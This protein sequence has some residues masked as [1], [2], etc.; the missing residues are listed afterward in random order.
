MGRI[1]RPLLRLLR[2][3]VQIIRFSVTGQA[4]FIMDIWNRRWLWL[5]G[6]M[7][8]FGLVFGMDLWGCLLGFVDHPVASRSLT[9]SATVPLLGL[10]LAWHFTLV[11]LALWLKLNVDLVEKPLVEWGGTAGKDILIALLKGAGLAVENLSL[12]K[13][14]IVDQETMVKK[15]ASSRQILIA[16]I[17]VRVTLILIPHPITMLISFVT[18]LMVFAL[19]LLIKQFEWDSTGG[20]LLVYRFSLFLGVVNLFAAIVAVFPEK[21]KDFLW[22]LA[23]APGTKVMQLVSIDAW[24]RDVDGQVL[25]A[26]AFVGILGA[27]AGVSWLIRRIARAD[28]RPIDQ[29]IEAKTKENQLEDLERKKIGWF[30]AVLVLVILAGLAMVVIRHRENIGVWLNVN[31]PQQTARQSSAPA[32]TA[33]PAPT[34]VREP[35]RTA[36]R[37][38]VHDEQG[39]RELDELD[40]RDQERLQR[41][42]WLR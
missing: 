34:P 6:P 20:R 22:G 31:E 8:I 1:I 25:I 38:Q 41:Y 14:S 15:V 2:G 35:A 40:R 23:V 36:A 37:P 12:G 10:L 18:S 11:G 4:Q 33:Q 13:L 26:L 32:T 9:G 24:K 29:R 17:L 21:A 19:V 16:A 42:S 30:R 7:A 3:Y 39:L 5:W 28:A 27:V